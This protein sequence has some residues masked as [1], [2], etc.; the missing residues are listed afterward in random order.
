MTWKLFVSFLESPL[1]LRLSPHGCF[2]KSFSVSHTS[3]ISFPS[4]QSCRCVKVN[5]MSIAV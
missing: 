5:Y 4:A 1:L 3:N 2:G